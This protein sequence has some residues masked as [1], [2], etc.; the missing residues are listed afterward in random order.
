MANTMFTMKLDTELRD[1]FMAEA[2]AADRPAAQIM[3]EFMREFIQKQKDEREYK[4]FL[5]RKVEK[6]RGQMLRGEYRTSEEVEAIFA[7]KRAKLR[8]EA[9]KNTL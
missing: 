9:G 2:A 5:R 7:A 3:R 4:E 1:E 6:A 8:R